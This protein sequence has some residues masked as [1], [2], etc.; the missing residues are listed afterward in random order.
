[1]NH[2][3]AAFQSGVEGLLGRF[4]FYGRAILDDGFGI[5]DID[6][7]EVVVPILVCGPGSLGKLAGSK[8]G[9]D[10]GGGSIKLVE[11]PE[12]GEG[13]IAG[14]SGMFLGFEGGVKFA[15]NVFSGLV[16]FVA[17]LAIAMHLFYVEVDVATWK[18]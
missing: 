13:L 15:E 16:D 9:I 8:G 11:D 4:L 2:S 1:M 5:F 12:F 6:I 14:F 7:T 17:E 3:K 18:A 10:F